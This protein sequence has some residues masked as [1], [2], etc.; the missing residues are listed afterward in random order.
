MKLSA[1]WQ[2]WNGASPTFE[3]SL[4]STTYVRTADSGTQTEV[5]ILLGD[6]EY[7]WERFAEAFGATEVDRVLIEEQV[8]V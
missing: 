4:D 7:E 3:S 8:K 5:P 1:Y 6:P 2:G